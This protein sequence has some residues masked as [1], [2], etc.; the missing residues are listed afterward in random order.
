[1]RAYVHAGFRHTV[2]QRQ[3]HRKQRRRTG[4]LN[5]EGIE[6]EP[7]TDLKNVVQK[8]HI[9]PFIG[10]KRKDKDFT[11]LTITVRSLPKFYVLSTVQL[12]TML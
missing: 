12:C 11:K 6:V 1:V 8:R 7:A 4:G 3:R 9:Q 10:L 2:E 5:A